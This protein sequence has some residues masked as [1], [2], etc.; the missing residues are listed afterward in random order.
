MFSLKAAVLLSVFASSV[1]AAPASQ[2]VGAAYFM[3]DD[4]LGNYIVANHIAQD[5]TVTFASTTYAGGQGVHGLSSI[6][7]PDGLFGQGSVQVSGNH[8]FVVNPAS[9]VVA[10]FAIDQE[11]P[12]KLTMVGDVQNTGWEWPTSIAINEKNGHVCVLNG[13]RLNGVQCF[14]SNAKTGLKKLPNTNRA[15]GLTNQ[16]TPGTGDPGSSSGILFSLD[17]TRLHVAVKG[18]FGPEG[19][20]QPGAPGHISTWTINADGSLGE[21]RTDSPAPSGGLL[22]FGM[23]QIR[24]T[25]ALMVADAFIG[26]N[27]YDFE[28][29][30]KASKSIAFHIPNQ[31]MACW[32]TYSEATGHYYFADFE[33]STIIEAKV[34]TKTL[35]PTYV[36]TYPL[37]PN[38]VPTDIAVGTINGQDYLF[39]L[40][41][42]VTQLNVLQLKPNGQSKYVQ[43]LDIGS[44]MERAKVTYQS[45]NLQGMAVYIKS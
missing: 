31:Q 8:L 32:A 22:P 41:P 26:A 17:G 10:M 44:A 4:P 18:Y 45:N 37:E 20:S 23:T 39:N 2:V 11:D 29:G 42:N 1:L 35:E 38:S 30:N 9:D 27:I 13:G 24:G 19:F 43:H 5:G 33:G 34:D 40:A 16:T 14:T 12:A 15:L 25:K 3:T 36:K 6:I 7:E 21:E 28:H